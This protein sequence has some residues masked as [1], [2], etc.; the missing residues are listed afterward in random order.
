MREKKV[1]VST[2]RQALTSRPTTLNIKVQTKGME[3]ATINSNVVEF[4]FAVN[5]YVL[6]TTK[7]ILL[8][9]DINAVASGKIGYQELAL[10]DLSSFR[11]YWQ[12]VP[13]RMGEI[14]LRAENNYSFCSPASNSHEEN[15]TIFMNVTGP[16]AGLN[17]QPTTSCN[18]EASPA[19]IY[20]SMLLGCI[21]E[22]TE[23]GA[24]DGNRFMGKVAGRFLSSA[25]NR[26]LGR[27]IIGDIDLKWWSN[28]TS[29]EQDTTYIRIPVSLS[30]FVPNLEAIF[31][32]TSDVSKDPRYD[33][34]IEF[35]LRYPL[36]IFDD[37]DISKNFIDPSLDISTNLVRRSYLASTES[38]Q[39]EDRLEASIGLA[40]RHRFW[41]PCILRIG[42]CKD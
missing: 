15:C 36:P 20:Y 7:N 28:E 30:K 10:F 21:S 41:D 38:G 22:N 5:V 16:L 1:I 40:Y 27:N 18:I 23:Y 25:G 4:P 13:L 39:S 24:F 11:L 34:S 42:Q 3:A 29:Q 26:I 37:A 6:G 32:Y 12:D 9:G 35:G 2:E 33:N 14:E 8:N 31:G 17:V 19:L